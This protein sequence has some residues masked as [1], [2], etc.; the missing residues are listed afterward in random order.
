MEVTGYYGSGETVLS[1]VVVTGYQVTP[2]PLIDSTHAVT[3]TYTDM[4]STCSTTQEVTVKHK[5]VS[6]ESTTPTV[7]TYKYGQQLQTA[8]AV[9]T[10]H[11]TDNATA[12]VTIQA[13][14]EPMTL[15]R[16]GQQEIT[17]SYTEEGVTQKTT[18]N[19][20][21]GKADGQLTADNTNINIGAGSGQTVTVTIHKH[22][23]DGQLTATSL[24]GV[25]VSGLEGT[26]ISFKG[27]GQTVI[28]SGQIT[29]TMKEGTNYTGATLV[30]KIHAE[31]WSWGNENEVGDADWWAGLK[32]WVSTAQTADLKNCEG[33]KKKVSLTSPV[34]GWNTA[35]MICI[36]AEIDGDK[37]L[38]FQTE[39]CSPST[40]NQFG[41]NAQTECNNF[42]KNCSASASL[43]TIKIKYRLQYTSSR[44]QTSDQTYE[45]Q[46]FL[47]SE[48]QMGLDQYS[49]ASD[50]YT[51]DGEQ[52]AYPYYTDN[53]KRV[54]HQDQPDGS[55]S[56]TTGSTGWY[57]ERSRRC[58]S[59]NCVCIVDTDGTPNTTGY[60][61]T[62]GRLAPAFVIG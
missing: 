48:C 34:C 20:T 29:I 51:V 17:V 54:K 12:N 32:N 6:I 27:D 53:G 24:N 22:G 39:M 18:F 25:T 45:C 28:E 8:G 44:N 49:I 55:G 52:T 7:S 21:V 19:V 33:R 3:I 13:K 9:V 47:P 50:E 42:A 1:E 15:N 11:Y 57:W 16:V 56:N 59:A 46:C 38:T 5:L 40:L 36:G 14:F 43:K 10:A 30:F 41:S 26:S 58:G 60:N 4:G 61:G 2:N 35:S 37:T 31:Y 23:S 62:S